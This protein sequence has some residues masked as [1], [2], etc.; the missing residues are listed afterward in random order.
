MDE[1]KKASTHSGLIFFLVIVLIFAGWFLYKNIPSNAASGSTGIQISYAEAPSTAGASSKR[2]EKLITV[3]ITGSVKNTGIYQIPASSRIKDALELAGGTEPL[4]DLTRTNLAKKLKDGE[5]IRVP[6]KKEEKQQAARRGK[7]S[8]NTGKN[9]TKVESSN[10]DERTF[11]YLDEG[12]FEKFENSDKININ[13]ATS[14]ELQKLPGVGKKLAERIIEYRNSIR[15]F[16]SAGELRD[17][18]GIGEKLYER[19]VNRVTL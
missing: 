1:E 14:E 10:G 4:A 19:I 9:N 2:K 12:T 5:M 7:K 13:T 16:E 15:G 17:V 3:Y 11:I 8:I 6:A 18:P